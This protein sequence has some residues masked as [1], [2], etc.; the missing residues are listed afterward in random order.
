[1]DYR[2]QGGNRIMYDT[3]K[4][5]YSSID[6]KRQFALDLYQKHG[7]T[8]LGSAVINEKLANLEKLTGLLHV[9]MTNMTMF[10]L[11]IDCGQSQSGGC[12]SYYMANETD[13][14]LLLINMLL[15]IKVAPQREDLYECCYLGRQGCILK[16]KPLFCLNYNCQKIL[17]GN[18]SAA[19]KK[20]ESASSAVLREQ[21]VLEDIILR[22]IIRT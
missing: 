2:Q 19:L 20:L 14:V 16:A 7:T 15:G 12:C 10:S 8:L 21:T 3:D 1:M 13:A 17:T 5:Y 22:K 11:C 4:I 18:D 9:Q 6:T